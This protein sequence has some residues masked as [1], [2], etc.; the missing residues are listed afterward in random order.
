MSKINELKFTIL[1]D[2]YTLI[3]RKLWSEWGLSILIEVFYEDGKRYT[4]LYDTGQ[5]GDVLIHNVNT[6]GIDLSKIDYIVLSHGHFDHTGG[7]LKALEKI[8]RKPIL[9][10]HPD[11]FSKKY[12]LRG[13]VLEYIGIP[14]NISEIEKYCNILTIKSSIEFLPNI[15]T[16]GEVVRYGYPEFTKDMYML[17]NDILIPDN[18][19]DDNALIMKLSDKLIIITGCGHSGILNIIKHAQE[20]TKIDK[21]YAIIGG[22]HL[23]HLDT[24]ELK[25]IIDSLINE[26]KVEKIYPCHCTGIKAITYLLQHYPDKIE[27]CGTGKVIKIKNIT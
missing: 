22:L 10:C 7:L 16:S 23:E 11:V 12:L 19:K 13:N 3:P 15:L 6:L 24:E 26:F 14:F 9:I 17:K 25:R 2:N 1:V 18:M 5:S 4:I 8:N 21:I 20:L 27:I